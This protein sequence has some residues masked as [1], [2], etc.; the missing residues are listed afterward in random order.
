MCMYSDV[1]LGMRGNHP[2]MWQQYIDEYVLYPLY[3]STIKRQIV[4]VSRYINFCM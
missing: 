4:H 1:E 2:G 3:K